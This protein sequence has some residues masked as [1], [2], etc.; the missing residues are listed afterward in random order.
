M[1]LFNL[2]DDELLFLKQGLELNAPLERVFDAS[3]A[4]CQVCHSVCATGCGANKS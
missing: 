2:T 1:T 4:P 3:F